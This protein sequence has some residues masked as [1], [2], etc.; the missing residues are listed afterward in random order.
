M[1]NHRIYRGLK[2]LLCI[3][4]VLVVLWG[5]SAIVFNFYPVSYLSYC[6]VPGL[7]RMAERWI[8]GEPDGY[9]SSS[10]SMPTYDLLDGYKL[11]TRH[12]I[13]G[14]ILQYV[15]AY[16]PYWETINP[17]IVSYVSWT[18]VVKE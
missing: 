1:R 5:C 16:D 14:W 12:K 10:N 6:I 3:F 17:Y 4:L 2:I 11:I 8:L 15:E 13:N 7:P 9:H 18:A